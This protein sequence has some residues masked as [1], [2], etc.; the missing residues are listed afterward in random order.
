MRETPL[1]SV[2]QGLAAKMTTFAGWRLPL[3]FSSVAEEARTARR[4]AVLFDISHLGLLRVF[5][6]GARTAAGQL[7][8][9]NPASI[10]FNC[11]SYALM[12]NRS[13]GII[14]DVWVMSETEEVMRLVVNAANHDRDLERVSAH[15]AA[16]GDAAVEDEGGRTFT[17]ALQ[18]PHSQEILKAAGFRGRMPMAFGAFFHGTVAEA[19]LLVSRSG[20]TGEDGFELFGTAQ[21]AVRVWIAIMEAGDDYGVLPAGLAA[22][23]V[24]RQE[25]GYP[26]W[27]QDLD[28]QTD[29]L[30][31][32][33]AWAID[34]DREFVGREALQAVEPRRRRVGLM[35]EEA[36]VARSGAAITVAGSKVGVVTSGTYSHNLGAAIG[37]GYVEVEVSVGDEVKVE[38]RGRE[39][40]ARISRMPFIV[41]RTRPSWRQIARRERQ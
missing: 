41:R 15:L 35:L 12:C 30:E 38:S 24:L 6:S 28:E 20:Y 16:S 7:L 33:L 23:D 21:D 37:Q 40:A 19:D 5:G 11:G 34:W 17:L 29:P 4:A 8:T 27:G 9:R 22:R 25:M 13:G 2:H 39:L 31:A 10:P 3:Q 26:L 18:G 36:G 1:S 32:G 14:D